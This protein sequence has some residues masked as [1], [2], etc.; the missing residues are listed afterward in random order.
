MKVYLEARPHRMRPV[1]RH[2][3]PKLVLQ[4]Q[5]RH[6]QGI[7]LCHDHDPTVRV[8]PSRRRTRHARRPAIHERTSR[9]HVYQED[10]DE[11]G[12]QDTSQGEPKLCLVHKVAEKD[13]CRKP[14]DDR[15]R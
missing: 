5:V 10:D 2:E 8:C 13:A 11:Q 6:A 7:S 12:R 14:V 3:Y 9:Y 15:R 4:R 1:A